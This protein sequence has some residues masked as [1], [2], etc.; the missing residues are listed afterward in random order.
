ML[1]KIKSIFVKKEDIE[2]NIKILYVQPRGFGDILMSTSIIRALK[3]K[4][5]DVDVDY[6]TKDPYKEILE[7]NPDIN[8]IYDWSNEIDSKSYTQVLRPY[9][10]TQEC[11]PDWPKLGLNLVD[12]YAL[13]CGIT[14]KDHRTHIYPKKID[15]E[16]FGI[17][18]EDKLICM[19]TKSAADIKDW[20]INNFIK[21]IEHLKD[22]KIITIGSKD[23]PKIENTINLR[24]I[25]IREVAYI[26]SKCRLFIGVDS[27]GVHMASSLGIPTIGLYGSTDPSE[28]R[29]L[30]SNKFMG[31][32]PPNRNGCETSCHLGKC[33]KHHKCIDNIPVEEVHKLTKFMLETHN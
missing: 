6:V 11:K 17:M 13:L 27:I 10:R 28:V 7:E 20:D 33:I 3:E 2:H 24:G 22:Y 16:K 29:P 8:K 30:S 14:L 23:D 19:H 4:Y 5:R 12:L 9:L 18:D 31:I 26:I 15:L 21:L 1:E 25:K 32:I